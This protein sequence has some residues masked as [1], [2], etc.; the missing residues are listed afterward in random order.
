ML[1]TS[2]LIY[3]TTIS[4]LNEYV[5]TG[6]YAED[7]LDTYSDQLTSL[8]HEKFTSDMLIESKEMVRRAL[9]EYFG[10]H[11]Y[12]ILVV[13]HKNNR[14]MI[15]EK[16]SLEQK[17]KSR[18]VLKIIE[19]LLVDHNDIFPKTLG[20]GV[21]VLESAIIEPIREIIASEDDIFIDSLKTAV[22][23]IMS[24][25][26]RDAT[27]IIQNRLYI[28]KFILPEVVK[29]KNINRRLDG[30]DPIIFKN[31]KEK[32]FKYD[33]KKEL[34]LRL[35]YLFS[36]ELNFKT[37]DNQYFYENY[38]RYF[39][40]TIEDMVYH[41]FKE[42]NAA[43]IY[44]VNYLLRENF[45]EMIVYAA[46]KLA[47]LATN[48]EGNSKTFL[49][50]YDKISENPP[51]NSEVILELALEQDR[52]EEEIQSYNAAIA[53]IKLDVKSNSRKKDTLLEEQEKHLIE[54]NEFQKTSQAIL[55]TL[56]NND[57]HKNGIN[58]R[59]LNERE[60]KLVDQKENLDK[61]TEQLNKKVL[62]YKQERQNLDKKLSI[63]NQNIKDAQKSFEPIQSKYLKAMNWLARAMVNKN[64]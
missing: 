39:Q 20:E 54:I 29:Q 35:D 19:R 22:R 28:K 50:Y 56:K 23:R 57:I 46:S 6:F 34:H 51:Y 16:A 7:F 40:Y 38:L 41:K 8:L 62:V 37:V 47:T 44:F 48:N 14:I 45:D 61:I 2:R 33:I 4:F 26:D 43:L 15:R 27:F 11:H 5:P 30:F 60:L 49:G 52:F 55:N 1:E 42:D 58:R 21:F 18:I 59:F 10:E 36:R 17:A 31:L 24:L 64:F 13:F 12:E 32:Y 53:R 63:E 9:K 25:H 3:D